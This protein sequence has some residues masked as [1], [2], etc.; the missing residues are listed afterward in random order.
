MRH[1]HDYHFRLASLQVTLGIR[2]S[3]TKWT[4][5]CLCCIPQFLNAY[6]CILVNFELK[7]SC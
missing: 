6:T 1:T 2:P 5:P 7:F 4:T 3:L